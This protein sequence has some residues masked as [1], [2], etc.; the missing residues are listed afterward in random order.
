MVKLN[1]LTRV[2]E[3][4]QPTDRVGIVLNSCLRQYRAIVC[5][6]ECSREQGITNACNRCHP[7]SRLDVTLSHNEITEKSRLRKEA[8][9]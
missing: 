6:N 9:E 7:E 1:T 5:R 2:Q 8:A 3:T 4:L